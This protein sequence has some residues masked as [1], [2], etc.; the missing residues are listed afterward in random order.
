MSNTISIPTPENFNFRMAVTGHGWYDLLPFEYD[1]PVGSLKYVFSSRFTR[2]P[3][4]IAI[5]EGTGSR[6]RVTV[7]DTANK[8]E[9]KE[10]VRHILRIDEDYDDFYSV[11]AE[12]RPLEWVEAMLAGR[13]LR[14]GSVFEDLVKTLCT[15]NC[16]WGLTKNMTSNLVLKLGKKSEGG[17]PAFPTADELA[18]KSETFYRE[19]VK[20]GYRSP[21]FVELGEAVASGR[22]DPESWLR[23]DLPTPELKREIKTVKGI[24]EYAADNLLKL[25]GRYDGLALDS[26]LRRGFYK[27]YNREKACPDKKIERHYRKFGKWKG[28]AM[29][30]DMTQEWFE[31]G[32]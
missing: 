4:S 9:V 21:Y 19:E 32:R 23:S 15:T 18:S 7:S 30:C 6:L 1:P 17:G 3:E 20:A 31:K 10:I 2:L 24:G 27:K 26:W 22:L 14:S 29:W 5:K 16:S 11:V 25:V 8:E 12:H 13:L 28:L